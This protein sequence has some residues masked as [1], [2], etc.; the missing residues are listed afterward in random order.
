M[1]M[2]M[3]VTQPNIPNMVRST[4]EDGE[5]NW[6]PCLNGTF[7]DDLLADKSVQEGKT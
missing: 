7:I 6:K 1:K 3:L 5:K 4:P 2:M